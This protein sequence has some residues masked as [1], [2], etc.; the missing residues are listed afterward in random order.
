MNIMN[1]DEAY[2]NL[3]NFK[4]PHGTKW[5]NKLAPYKV[6]ACLDFANEEFFTTD[7]D[8]TQLAADLSCWLIYEEKFN[9]HNE[10]SNDNNLQVQ[11]RMLELADKANVPAFLILTSRKNS[12]G[13]ICGTSELGIDWNKYIGTIATLYEAGDIQAATEALGNGIADIY[14]E[15]NVI[16]IITN[17]AAKNHNYKNKRIGNYLNNYKGGA[18]VGKINKLLKAEFPNL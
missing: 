4:S 6:L 18:T 9:S 3:R 14:S 10:F 8:C 12:K 1:L 2:I 7:I 13:I 11:K 5:N 16:K 17:E 15:S